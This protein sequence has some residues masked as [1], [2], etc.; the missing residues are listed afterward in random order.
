MNEVIYSYIVNMFENNKLG[1]LN[2][3]GDIDEYG[4]DTDNA[5]EFYFGNYGDGE[6]AFRWYSE[7][8]FNEE[9]EK[10]PIIEIDSELEE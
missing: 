5:F 9:C 6:T 7:E 1:D 10:C 4:N 3:I 8:Y 2:S